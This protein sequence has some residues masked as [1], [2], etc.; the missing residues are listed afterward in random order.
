MISDRRTQLAIVGIFLL[1]AAGC[2]FA[3]HLLPDGG[4]VG[5]IG[6]A[7]WVTGFSVAA[8][9]VIRI[10]RVVSPKAAAR[11]DESRDSGRVPLLAL[12]VCWLGIVVVSWIFLFGMEAPQTTFNKV[13]MVVMWCGVASA[14]VFAAIGTRKYLRDRRPTA[15]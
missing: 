11:M 2:F 4:V 9:S 12:I 13:A 15:D 10:L 8:S 7:F 5:F 1:V 6:T 3:A 14:A